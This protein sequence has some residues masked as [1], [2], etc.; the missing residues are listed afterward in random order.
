[1][2]KIEIKRKNHVLEIGEDSVCAWHIDE[3]HRVAST[4]VIR[5]KKDD[6]VWEIGLCA[7]VAPDGASMDES[8][9]R[10]ECIRDA[11]NMTETIDLVGWKIMLKVAGRESNEKC[12]IIEDK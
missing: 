6:K 7:N 3:S 2:R 8:I 10:C 11:L 4:S 1:M 5:I 12:R 9:F